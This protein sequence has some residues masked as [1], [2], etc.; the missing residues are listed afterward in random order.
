MK[1][2]RQSAR[3]E[4]DTSMAFGR[5]MTRRGRLVGTRG[6]LCLCDALQTVVR[7]LYALGAGDFM[8]TQITATG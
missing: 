7:T 6:D 5:S 3:V 2:Y 8:V 1:R 4:V